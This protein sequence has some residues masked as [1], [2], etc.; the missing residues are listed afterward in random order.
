MNTNTAA[1]S[2]T[3]H[4]DADRSNPFS[5]TYGRCSNVSKRYKKVSRIGEGT[6]GI[7]YKAI[8]QESDNQQ[9][10]ALKR[11]LPHH[12]ASDGFPITTL[13]EIQILREISSDDGDD[14]ENIVALKEVTVGSKRSSVFLVFEYVHFDLAQLIDRHYEK[15]SKSPFTIPQT[16]CLA[17]QLLSALKYLH[18][19]CIIHRDLKLSNLL[20]D[21]DKG[22]LKLADF[23]LAR[24]ME[25]SERQRNAPYD[26]KERPPSHRRP[27]W[28]PS[29]P[30]DNNLTP[31]VVSL[32]YRSP[33][34][35]LN[36]DSY[37]MAIDQWAAGCVIAE[38]LFGKPLFHGKNEIDQLG[39]IVDILGPPNVRDWPEVLDM[40][41]V[42]TGTAEIPF[43]IQAD[44]YHDRRMVSH[45]KLLDLF[46]ELT[47][48]GIELFQH[49]FKYNPSH[50][51]TAKVACECK[52][53]LENPLPSDR[54][55]MPKFDHKL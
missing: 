55:C 5:S 25:S 16:K 41:L 40:P 34:L 4:V 15:Y 42:R 51:W 10:V 50:R 12:E 14:H 36:A 30:Q 17:N 26:T 6:Y 7:V 45:G 52:W 37:T 35:L 8:D 19:R 1:P 44:S 48:G 53:F 33:E 54:L 21:K 3:N 32:W 46:S 9:I 18:E 49:L 2:S 20:Y 22:L 31:K 28:L 13:R 38:L 47:A 29:A 27:S 43:L 24:K 23:G 39:K 11:C